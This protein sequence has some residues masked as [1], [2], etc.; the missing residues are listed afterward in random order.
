MTAR[1]RTPDAVAV[2]LAGLTLAVL[3]PG[4]GWGLPT[5]RDEDSTAPWGYDEFDSLQPL[6][7]ARAKFCRPPDGYLQYPLFHYVVVAGAYVP[8]V[9]YEYAAGT[10]R[11]KAGY[12]YGMADPAWTCDGLTLIARGVSAVMGVG[13]VLAAFA[14]SRTLGAT[15]AVAGAVGAGVALLPTFVYYGRVANVDVPYVF[16]TL[17]AL[18]AAADVAVAGRHTA[19]PF[20]RFGAFAS[21]AVCTK[22]QAYAFLVP[23][24]PLLIA[25]LYARTP[26]TWPASKRFAA[27]VLS[28]P[29]WLGF[30]AAVGAFAVGNNLVFGMP[31]FLAHV[32]KALTQAGDYREH[33]DDIG[34]HLDLLGESAEQLGLTLGPAVV[35]ALVGLVRLARDR[36]YAALW[37]FA[38]P[39][40][41]HHVLVVMKVG[42]VYP[43]FMLL[44]AILGM[45]AA[46]AAFP[47]GLG[48]PRKAALSA[49]AGVAFA[50]LLY[51]AADVTR[52]QFADARYDAGAYLADHATPGQT[53]ESYSRYSRLLPAL[54][55]G[56]RLNL[57]AAGDIDAA[58]LAARRPDFILVTDLNE[59]AVL[60]APGNVGYVADLLGGRL[61]Y[62]VVLDRQTPSRLGRRFARCLAPHVVLLE[63][64]PSP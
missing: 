49:V 61:G 14:L 27:A 40:V 25:A 3:L 51:A 54:P 42:Y 53:V 52:A 26:A 39:A 45:I 58:K 41:A 19:G 6:A 63:R 24:P 35:L 34:G 37:L 2:L 48:G 17:L 59:Q 55:A 29:L 21:L 60:E 22:D 36:H 43:R 8:Y 30:A 31:G 18:K 23:L 5:A 9:G 47:V 46:G 33:V 44:P 16:W 7:E 12:P 56:V 32:R 4:L 20:V 10:F 57:V 13:C 28:R 11:P 64:G 15:R 1:L 38:A 50:Y 62:R